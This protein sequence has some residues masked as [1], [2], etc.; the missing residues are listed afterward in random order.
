MCCV[1]SQPSGQHELP[2]KDSSLGKVC[3]HENT[4]MLYICHDM[5]K[6]GKY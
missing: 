3:C 2:G 6:V 4:I 5:G 1:F